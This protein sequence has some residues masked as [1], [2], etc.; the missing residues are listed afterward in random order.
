MSGLFILPVAHLFSAG[1]IGKTRK[2]KFKMQNRGKDSG[3]LPGFIP[4]RTRDSYFV[5]IT[6]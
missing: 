2:I 5:G 6:L 4:T 3:Y 1:I